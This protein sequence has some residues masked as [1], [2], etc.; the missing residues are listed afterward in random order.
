MV[1]ITQWIWFQWGNETNFSPPF[2]DI[3]H[4]SAENTEKI[5]FPTQTDK[6]MAAV[7]YHQIPVF[8]SRLHGFVSISSS[9]FDN[10]DYFNK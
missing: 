7:I 3:I 4:P 6:L 1:R 10:A 2:A 5:E 9:D 8:F